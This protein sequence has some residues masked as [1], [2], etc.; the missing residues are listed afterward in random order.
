MKAVKWIT[1][2]CDIV[3]AHL[4][5]AEGCGVYILGDGPSLVTS[6][7]TSHVTSS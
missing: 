6:W 3:T 5:F 1:H 4:I 2:R 7:T